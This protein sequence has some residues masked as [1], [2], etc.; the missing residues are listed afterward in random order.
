[1]V[2]GAGV[3]AGRVLSFAWVAGRRLSRCRRNHS[4]D[5]SSTQRYVI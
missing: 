2:A 3:H 4:R 5:G 1:L